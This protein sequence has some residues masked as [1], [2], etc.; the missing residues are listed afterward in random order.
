[1]HSIE[2]NEKNTPRATRL[3]EDREKPTLFADLKRVTNEKSVEE[4]PTSN[5]VMHQ[6]G[7][8]GA[9]AVTEVLLNIF[10]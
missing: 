6:Y 8:V 9:T 4:K 1:M 3:P 2:P 5:P 10:F 7:V